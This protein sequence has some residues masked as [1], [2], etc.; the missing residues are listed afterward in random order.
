[1]YS[2]VERRKEGINDNKTM[3]KEE[4]ATCTCARREEVLEL[5]LSKAT[6]GKERS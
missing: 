3:E 4:G 2:R 6:G 5:D 1:M